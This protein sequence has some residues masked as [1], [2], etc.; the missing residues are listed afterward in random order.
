MIIKEGGDT[1]Y[2]NTMVKGG[3]GGTQNMT[4]DENMWPRDSQ[5]LRSDVVIYG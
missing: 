4:V 5:P 3:G 1:T 2:Y